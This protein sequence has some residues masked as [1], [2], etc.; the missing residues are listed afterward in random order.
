MVNGSNFA[1]ICLVL[2]SE[3]SLT[4]LVNDVVLCYSILSSITEIDAEELHLDTLV[5]TL[6]K[7]Q[8][9]TK[10]EIKQINMHKLFRK[11]NKKQGIINVLSSKALKCFSNFLHYLNNETMHHNLQ[12]KI[13]TN[14][15]EI[16]NAISYTRFVSPTT[17]A[18]TKSCTS[19]S[20]DRT[21]RQDMHE[22]RMYKST[23]IPLELESSYSE[24]QSPCQ[25]DLTRSTSSPLYT[26]SNNTSPSNP[27]NKKSQHQ[28]SQLDTYSE[29]L[30][31]VH[32]RLPILSRQGWTNCSKTE[33]RFIYVTV[34]KSQNVGKT[35]EYSTSFDEI[36]DHQMQYSGEALK[37][38]N[39]M[40]EAIDSK[41][42]QLILLEGN[43]GTGKTTLAFKFCK[44]WGEGNALSQ[45]SH[46]IL[47]Q[48]RDIKDGMM[49]EPEKLFSKMGKLEHQI[50]VEMFANSGSGVL[51]WLEG[52]DELVDNLKFYSVFTDLLKGQLFPKATV[53][54]S[55]R[56]SATGSLKQYYTF[57]HK[58]KLVGF[59][60]KQIEEY[61]HC[62][63]TDSKLAESFMR[64][65]KHVPSLAQLAEVPM[66]LAILVKLFKQTS[67]DLPNTLT[68]IFHDYLMNTLQH[69]K[70]KNSESKSLVRSTQNL[71]P[72]MQKIFDTL[73]KYAFEHLFHHKPFSEEE[74]SD[75]LFHSSDVPWDFDGLGMF[76]VQNRERVTGESK[77]YIFLYKPIQELLAALYLTTLDP[78]QQL[79]Q[80]KEIFGNKG[81]EMVWVFYAG[82]TELRVVPIDIILREKFNISQLPQQSVTQLPAK[83]LQQLVK[84]WKCCHSYF[85][86][87]TIPN[88]FSIEFLLT[89]ILCCY[90]ARNKEACRIIAMHVYPDIVCRIEI[91]PNRVTPYLLLAVSYFISHSTKMWSLRCEASIQSGVELLCKY[92]TDPNID[93]ESIKSGLWVWCYVVKS[94]QIDAYC[95]AIKYQSSLQWI[96]LLN[97]SCLGDDGTIKLCDCLAFDR[98]VI[99]VEIENCKIGSR[100]LK[101]IGHM[102]NINGKILHIDLR[103]NSFLLEDVRDFLCNIKNQIYLEYL[104]LDKEFTKNFSV[105]SILKE[106]N[107]IRGAKNASILKI[108]HQ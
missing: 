89:L 35:T 13:I 87:M 8:L 90:E 52:W 74:I 60:Y 28:P 69:H 34:V 79:I 14:M 61:V 26:K 22:N 82:I 42:F 31:R 50:Y 98:T 16:N 55:T 24:A 86:D 101:S 5:Q 17:L 41:T 73:T 104:L 43:A 97:G 102:L 105:T 29:H 58:F 3:E 7:E 65:L 83:T 56:P 99:K 49:N 66:N 53:V 39:K 67:Q 30:K 92:I 63:C 45:Y 37:I 59:K 4:A 62:Y 9:L 12:M 38:Y 64:Q 81:Y 19:Q 46:V 40:F 94:S 10:A 75:T 27:L 48:L 70:Y 2:H 77:D 32:Q 11:P 54:V 85:M 15:S 108:S 93:E 21:S 1:K 95:K 18:S 107:S 33:D 103:K 57:T 76:E 23:S 88:E 68:E 91:P 106:I 44:D 96:H 6:T 47:L 78:K 25:A 51:F 80:L 71:P 72:E 36:L 20:S 100:G 84:A